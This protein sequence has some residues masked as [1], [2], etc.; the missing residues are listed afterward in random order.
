MTLAATEAAAAEVTR[1][2]TRIFP[3]SFPDFRISG[4][5]DFRISG[6]PDFR[7]SGLAIQQR[8]TTQ[9]YNREDRSAVHAHLINVSQRQ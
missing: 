5:P 7:I 2:I 4:F 1:W 9:E 8:A 3:Y 6:F